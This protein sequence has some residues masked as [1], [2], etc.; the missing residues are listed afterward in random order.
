MHECPD[1]LDTK[2]ALYGDFSHKNAVITVN[3]FHLGC[4]FFWRKAWRCH[5]GRGFATRRQISGAEWS[6][7]TAVALDHLLPNRLLR[8]PLTHAATSTSAPGGRAYRR[9]ARYFT[10]LPSVNPEDAW[11]RSRATIKNCFSQASN[12]KGCQEKSDS[13]FRV[14]KIDS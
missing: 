9:L 2:V 14:V 4:R 10:S 8:H 1:D 12:R 11:Q 7:I 5:H 13:P 6:S 3:N